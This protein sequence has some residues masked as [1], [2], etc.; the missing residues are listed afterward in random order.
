[1]QAAVYLTASR[2]MC[3]CA[4]ASGSPSCSTGWT[5]WRRGKEGDVGLDG[6][7]GEH[8][9]MQA[10]RRQSVVVWMDIYR[11]CRLTGWSVLWG[12]RE[13]IA[14]AQWSFMNV[15]SGLLAD[16]LCLS[17]ALWLGSAVRWHENSPISHCM[18]RVESVR[19]RSLIA[20]NTILLVFSHRPRCRKDLH[21]R[22]Y[23]E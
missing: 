16:S 8:I 14:A 21:L 18:F 9:V 20:S 19:T 6:T 15:F 2:P 7:Q 4:V 22:E 13:S 1:M 12:E 3:A 17:R 10:R 5:G 11:C 23:I